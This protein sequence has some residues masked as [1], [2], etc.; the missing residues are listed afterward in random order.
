MPDSV[1]NSPVRIE[2]IATPGMIDLRL[3]FPKG[4]AGEKCLS[5][6]ETALG[7][8]LPTT[9][10]RSTRGHYGT[11]PRQA[12]WM[13]PDQWL[14]LLSPDRVAEALNSLAEAREII[15]AN[16]M[17]TD[18]SSAR[19]IIR[20]HGDGVREV[21]MKAIAVDFLPPAFSPGDVRRCAFS[22]IAAMVYCRSDTPDEFD[23]YFFRS[24]TAFALAWLRR[25][26]MPAAQVHLFRDG[27]N[28]R[29]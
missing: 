11:E 3:C 7:I 27:K 1:A 13:S 21:L 19:S 8:P 15:D 25:A 12:L 6:L 22:N 23:L 10:R 4:E 28:S 9:P 18:M 26:A 2:E 5:A 20:L 29:T 16:L 24:Y 14:I 17:A